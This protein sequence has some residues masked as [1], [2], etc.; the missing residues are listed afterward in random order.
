MEDGFTPGA[1]PFGP[2]HGPDGTGQSTVPRQV[3]ERGG[4]AVGGQVRE[5]VMPAHAEPGYP[6]APVRLVEVVIP[7][8]T[9]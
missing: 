9:A 6:A 5:L 3:A 7:A 2:G 8:F 1:Q 4:R